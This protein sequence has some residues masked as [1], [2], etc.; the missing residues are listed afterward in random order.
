MT[1]IEKLAIAQ[2]VFKVV[3]DQVSTKN[4]SS[5]RSQADNDLMDMYEKMG[6]KSIDLKVNGE[7]VGTYSVTM[8]KAT[9]EKHKKSIRITDITKL[10]SWAESNPDE[11]NEW[12]PTA[13]EDFANY[14]FE[15][16]GE[17]PDG[18][19]VV[20][21]V[22]PATKE[23]PKGTTLRVEP[24]KVATALKGELPEVVAGLLEGE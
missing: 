10:D 15:Q 7:K 9:P 6:V 17:V 20:D 23:R 2:A 21:E 22:T 11:Y 18:C 8:A 14:C 16:Y 3:A 12:L 1:D 4:P 13:W 19:E 5:I 24:Q